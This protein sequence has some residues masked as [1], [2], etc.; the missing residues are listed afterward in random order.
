[1]SAALL[2]VLLT[3]AVLASLALFSGTIGNA[4]LRHTL[5]VR[6]SIPASLVISSQVAPHRIDEA[7]RA[8]AQGARKTFDGLPVTL[9][10][11]QRSGTYALPA[12]PAEAGAG[13]DGL[14]LTH[15]AAVDRSRIR[16]LSGALPRAGQA[17]AGRPP[18]QVAVPEAAA[19]RMDAKS[20]AILTLVDRVSG[21]SLNIRVTG[22]YRPLD[23][24]DPYWQADPLRG[25]GARTLSFTTYGPLVAAP[26]VLSSGLTSEGTTTWVARADYGQ[27]TAERVERLGAAVPRGLAQLR[28]APA[29]A[30]SQTAAGEP[31]VS[32]SLP[33]VLDHFSKSLLV[34]RSA[35]MIVALQL[36][37]L[38]AAAL[39]LVGRLL[40]ADR[41]AHTDLLRARGA[42][43]R[44]II[45]MAWLEALVP[46]L[47]GALCAPLLAA[48]LTRF[49]TDHTSVGR[50]D[51]VIET[52][53]TP[54]LWLLAGV[55]ALGCAAALAPALAAG[56]R[57]GR[58]GPLPGPLKA[59]A[60]VSLLAVATV[61]CWQLSGQSGRTGG[62]ALS[63]SA[64]G[65]LGVDP[66]LVLAPALAL[67]A[68][69]VLVLRII[70][71]VARLAE[72]RAER[73]R[74]LPAALVAW[75][76]GR[77]PGHGSGPVLLLVLAVAM[78]MLALAQ[79]SSW[80]RSQRDQA[81]FRSGASVRVLDTPEGPADADRFGSLPGVTSVAPAY[82]KTINL[83][84]NRTATILSLDTE[85]AAER[86]LLRE[87]LADGDV[88]ALLADTRAGV[89]AERAGLPL[90]RRAENVTLRVSVRNERSGSEIKGF[91]PVVTVEVRDK[92][93]LTYQLPAGSLP[94]GRIHH[95]LRVT[96]DGAKGH[97]RLTP[98]GPLSIT[99]MRLAGSVP[100][101]FDADVRLDVERVWAQVDDRST[102]LRTEIPSGL[103][104]QGVAT[105]TQDSV[106]QKQVSLSPTSSP[107][108]PLSVSHRVRSTVA[109]G[110]AY[111]PSESSELRL[112]VHRPQPPTQIPGVATDAFMQ[113]AGARRGQSIDV[114]LSGADVRVKII[115]TLR[116]LPTTGDGAAPWSEAVDGPEV[117]PA[118]PD[119]RD[120]GALLLDLRAVNDLLARR[121]GGPLSPTEWWLGTDPGRGGEVA[122]SL[123]DQPETDPSSVLVRDETAEDLLN[124]PLGG[125]PRSALLF[126]AFAAVVLAAVGFV[127]SA[128]GSLRERR[129]EHAVLYALGYS[130]A[131]LSRQAAVE[132]S[133]LIAIA[134]LAGVLL[135]AVLTRVTVPLTILT[136]RAVRPAPQVLIDLPLSHLALLL[137]GTALLPLAT[138]VALALRR[139]RTTAVLRHQGDN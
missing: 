49:L 1:M 122:R 32:T 120:G 93:G 104:W 137:V 40:S 130:R 34:A 47:A 118:E 10:R 82:R 109:K 65:R 7:E 37:L 107:R 64:S 117:S 72:R 52:T 119:N 61:A 136:D 9:S 95:D 110:S 68:G 23:T 121:A 36:T 39:L 30:D 92:Y 58:T 54:S 106:A 46:V 124:D 86:L 8:A 102:P 70:P 69:T 132:Q 87:D 123:R 97:R 11:M 89:S 88:A 133:V 44:R 33:S 128:I 138:V 41:A 18:V 78:S 108:R 21:Q 26:S 35:L 42:S 25:R 84:G 139:V 63:R 27:M 76:F 98:A 2:V 74:S 77:R 91:E 17:G 66:L 81:D 13:G 14:D 134:L 135:G 115:G 112:W 51:V 79:S 24:A 71:L 38:A 80:S 31:Q 94:A 20:G 19:D 105:A 85:R 43:R 127:I 50:L 62:G 111:P 100:P 129:A 125:S 101:G 90:P 75:Q 12:D 29:L 48:P 56:G 83:S 4:A 15:F 67:L 96:L 45:A 5:G 16:L 3:S 53:P 60:D 22:I 126:A 114:P 6:E 131:S 73:G 55:L 28:S 99:G 103:L 113:A 57:K 116:Q 59:G